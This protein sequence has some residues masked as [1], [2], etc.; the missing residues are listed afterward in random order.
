[1]NLFLTLTEVKNWEVCDTFACETPNLT[2]FCDTNM[3]EL[4]FCWNYVKIAIC[5][6]FIFDWSARFVMVNRRSFCYINFLQRHIAHAAPLICR[7]AATQSRFNLNW[8]H[9][10]IKW[11]ELTTS[12]S[13]GAVCEYFLSWL[14]SQFNVGWTQNID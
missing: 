9:G 13:H 2:P 10:N 12:L 3:F 7:L 14:I 5:F 4:S 1:M 8:S 11:E 6:F